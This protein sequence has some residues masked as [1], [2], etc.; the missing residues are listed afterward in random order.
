M[1]YKVERRGGIVTIRDTEVKLESFSYLEISGR[2]KMRIFKE[3]DRAFLI[4]SK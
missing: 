3:D 1:Q 4:V 2:P